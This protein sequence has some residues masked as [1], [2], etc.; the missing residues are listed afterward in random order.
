MLFIAHG[1][2][3]GLHVDAVYRFG[4]QGAQRV[5]LAPAPDGDAADSKRQNVRRSQMPPQKERL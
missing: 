5:G 4:K 1:L 2:P 3:K